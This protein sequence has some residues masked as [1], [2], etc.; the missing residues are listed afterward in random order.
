MSLAAARALFMEFIDSTA[1][2]TALPTLARGFHSDPVHLKLALTSYIVALAVFAP[3]SGWI[4]DRFGARRVFLWAMATFLLGSALCGFSR[5]LPALVAARIVQGMGGAMMTPVGRLIVVA[6]APRSRLVSAMSWFTT[7]ALLGPLL[8]PPLAGLIL[9]FADWPWIVFVN[10]PVGVAGMAAVAAVVPKVRNAHPGRFDLAGFGLSV[11]AITALVVS[12]ETAG[13]GLLP[14]PFQIAAGALSIGALVAYVLHARRT[15]R[16]LLQLS[17]FRY[18]TYRASLLGGTIVRLGLGASPF[19]LP[20]LLQV[21]LGWSALQAGLV[22]VSIGA[23]ALMAKPLM[24]PLLR[25]VGFRTTLL[26]AVLLVALCTAAPAT[27]RASVPVA[28]ILGILMLSGFF[29]AVQ[30]TATNTLAY[31]DVP[32]HLMSAASTLA[33]VTQQIGLSLG[34]SVGGLA[35]HLSRGDGGAMTPECFAGPFVAI[36]LLTLL[37][38]PVYTRLSPGAGAEISGRPAAA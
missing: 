25:R 6:S 38:L 26:C 31:A 19:L 23:G 3:A 17:L 28:L 37:A 35:L 21:G 14:V 11:L 2:S 10:L 22:S 24:P 33:A 15:P 30:F 32:P 20:L 27:F 18:T 12:S 29:R 4:A 9:G 8:G 13:L 16:P 1:L 7:P 36:G 34:I 5:T